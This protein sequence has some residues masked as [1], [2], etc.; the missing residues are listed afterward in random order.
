M[1]LSS[2]VKQ[3]ALRSAVLV[4]GKGI[5]LAGR[6]AITRM[7]GA[8]GI[9]LYQIAYSFFGMAL[10][11]ISGGLPTTLALF[12]AKQSDR[13]W[14]VFQL[15]SVYTA[16]IGLGL[17]FWTQ[18]YAESIAVLI[19]DDELA[20]ALRALA[21]AL[22]A[23]PLL[24]LA[25]GYMQGIR[26][27][28]AISLSELTEQAVRITVLIIF[29]S[30]YAA[31]GAGRAIGYGLYGTTI[32]AIVAF[33]FLTIYT[34]STQR[35][36]IITYS[37]LSKEG[38]GIFLRSSFVIGCTRMLVPLSDFIDSILIPNRLQAAGN[39]IS[40]SIAMYG[41]IT[42]MAAVIVYMPTMI[43]ASVSYTVTM[44]IA[45][46]HEAGMESGR[47]I[48][49]I[50]RFVWTWGIISGLFIFLY[51]KE[52]AV[53]LFGVEAAAE[54][55]RYLS[56]IPLI[57]GLRELTTSILWAQERKRTPLTGLALGIGLSAL[58]QFVI[59]AIPGFGYSGAAIGILLMETV[60]VLWNLRALRNANVTLFRLK[61]VGW[62]L[63]MFS[64]IMLVLIWPFIKEGHLSLI[65]LS[66][67][68]Y[69]ISAAL[70][71]VIRYRR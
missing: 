58:L 31:Q 16:L 49:R 20:W 71:I 50:L 1:L 36:A 59:V 44:K 54:P 6:V 43:T 40:D 13:G 5:G 28:E 34:S 12:T 32:A 18:H 64:C 55:I 23:V 8:E 11:V 24:Q 68:F 38:L 3:T 27:Y 45:A 47:D 70:L 33:V 29:V 65:V 39:S 30:L 15:L 63:I 66:A 14:R 35:A 69:W 4:V 53:L 57:V 7:L 42:G 25:R 48:E 46:K 22:I 52:A 19:G 51:A 60:A 62:E 26:S 10:M 56:A 41:I 61:W 9:G 21:P 37:P 2:L 17:A 67:L